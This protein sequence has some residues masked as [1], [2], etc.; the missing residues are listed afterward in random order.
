MTDIA[1]R[2]TPLYDLRL[3]LGRMLIEFQ[4]DLNQLETDGLK[5]EECEDVKISLS[6]AISAFSK[7]GHG[8]TSVHYEIAKLFQK[9]ADMYEKWNGHEG[10]DPG[11]PELRRKELTN[12]NLRRKKLFEKLSSRQ[13][14]LVA[15][16]QLDLPF[17][18]SVRLPL[19][20]LAIKQKARFPRLHQ[21][22]FLFQ[23]K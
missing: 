2:G 5:P 22:T 23:E 11:K 10:N 4:S 13:A 17:V 14:E 6:E 12:L 7:Q 18:S 21:S 9:Y 19:K 16:G 1:A 8:P 15:S 20:Q 3:A